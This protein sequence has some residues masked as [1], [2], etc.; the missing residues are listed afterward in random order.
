MK[1]TLAIMLALIMVLALVPTV[2]FAEEPNKIYVDAT[3]GKDDQE[4]VGTTSDKAYKSLD[5]AM[6]AAVSGDT[7]YLAAGTYCGNSA[8]PSQAGNG[9]KK[10]LTFVGAGSDK[11]TWQIRAME[12]NT[13]G[14]GPC[15]YSFDGS[16]R[17]TFEKMTVVGSVYPDGIT[18]KA[19]DYQGFVRINHLKL[20]DCTFNGR[21]D[22]WGYET[23]EF[24]NVTFYAPGTEA[25]GI[26]GVGYSLWTWTGTE[27]TFNNCTFNSAG[28]VINVYHEDPKIATTINFNNCTVS[29]TEP[30]SLSVMNIN[31]TYVDS[32]TINFNGKN[33][34]NDIKADGIH[35][36]DGSHAS[37]AKDTANKK[38]TSEQATCSKLFE[39]NMKYGNG[40]NGKTTVKID[41]QTVWK[42]GQRVSHAIDTENDKYTD[43]YKDN[44]FEIIKDDTTGVYVKTCKY[45]GYTE[46]FYGE[47]SNEIGLKRTV[48]QGQEV[49]IETTNPKDTYKV[50]G[51][52]GITVDYTATMDM[53]KLKW[54]KQG[55][56][57][58]DEITPWQMLAMQPGWITKDTV[59]F[60]KFT[61]DKN[62]DLG[63][64]QT[65]YNNATTSEAKEKLL[66]LESNM[67]KIADE[68]GVQFDIEK[69]EMT[70]KCNWNWNKETGHAPEPKITLNGYGL[71]VKNDWNGS[72]QIDITN[73]GCVSG[74]VH[75]KNP[76]TEKKV[77]MAEIGPNVAVNQVSSATPSLDTIQ[78]PI[79]GGCKTDEFTLYYGGGGSSGDSGH[80][81]Y[82]PTTTPVPVIV[83]P[84]KTGDMTVWQSILHFLGIK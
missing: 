47:L 7:I 6:E 15:D 40:N 58:D 30:E 64:F 49:K 80:S 43:G 79:V 31:D 39:F 32:F 54:E 81:Y 2:A 51:S 8:N 48:R 25:S 1:K 70:I 66:K 61:F 65:N 71:P 36:T 84:P 46:P 52:S 50:N 13:S 75:I 41:G 4:G 3:N 35:E 28:K 19:N 20:K 82:Y 37:A 76:G 38:K 63:T 34:I 12:N 74:T 17:I 14:D 9:A 22:Y 68:G 83:I 78:I 77:A 23:T 72:K 42:G 55:S 45:C 11:T 69:R 56:L 10:N 73:S 26:K 67:F 60:L 59:V 29:S 5:K 27:Y 62:I 53:T 21:A 33:T 18:I 16:D 57:Y 24:E 44:A